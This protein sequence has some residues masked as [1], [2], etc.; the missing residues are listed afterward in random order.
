MSKVSATTQL[1]NIFRGI[2]FP[3][4][5]LD[6]IWVISLYGSVAFALAVLIDGYV[7]PKYDPV[8][9]EKRSSIII[10]LQIIGQLAL[11]GFIAI[12]ICSALERLPSPFEGMRGYTKRSPEA[13]L[14]RNP[15]I[16]S[17]ILFAL[18]KSLQGRLGIL[19]ARAT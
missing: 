15:A 4:M 2:L 6:Y 1:P 13:A 8:K 10:F 11:Q 5:F 18:S 17:V 3:A 19:F 12:M 7:L 9:A 14:M 16:I